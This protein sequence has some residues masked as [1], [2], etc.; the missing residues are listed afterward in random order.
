[1]APSRNPDCRNRLVAIDGPVASGKTA[2]GRALAKRLGWRLFDTGIMYR[3]ATWQAQRKG[4]HLDEEDSVA[5]LIRASEFHLSPRTDSDSV[6]MDV[7]VDGDNA[8]PHLRQPQVESG[9]PIV[10]ANAGVREL[11]VAIQQSEAAQGCMIV[12]GRDIGTVVLPNAPA[13]IFL[14]ARDEVRARRRAAENKAIGSES[15]VLRAIRRRDA[16]DQGRVASP[17]SHSSDEVWIDTSDLTLEQSI[18][19]AEAIIR[20]RIPGLAIDQS[21]PTTRRS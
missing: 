3:A 5:E 11:M 9:V 18:D 1:M 12:V 14:D 16:R 15:E 10:A 19:I 21:T 13:K 2:V 6:E 4:V 20:E 7:F 8:T 17:L